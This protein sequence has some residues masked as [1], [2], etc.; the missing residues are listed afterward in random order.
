MRLSPKALGVFLTIAKYGAP[1]GVKGLQEAFGWG[2]RE[3]DTA[4]AEL[5]AMRLIALSSG[6]TSKGTF[7]HKIE[8]T[9]EGKA[10]VYDWN[11]PL[12]ILPNGETYNSISLNSSMAD[13]YIADIPYSQ[14]QY[15]LYANSVNQGAKQSFAQR[16][17]E[18]NMSLGSM[19]E[20]PDDIAAEKEKD[21]K[22]KK[23]KRKEESE[24]FYRKRQQVRANKPIEKWT[25]TDIVNYFAEQCKNVW[26]VE[27]V[28]ITQRPRLVR[29]MDTFRTDND[30]DG[31]LDKK[32]MDMFLSTYKF[33]HGRLYNPEQLFW[34]FLNYAP[35]AID[36]AKRSLQPEDVD[37]VSA[38]KAKAKAEREEYLRSMGK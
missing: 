31:V 29:A 30:T 22:R 13:T 14:E 9:Q 5:A 11:Q 8:L 17:E 12:Y 37:V 2:R 24:A 21:A 18:T 33:D 25:P 32:L 19:P 10:F 28:A 15:G 34:T 1:R 23:E 6:K 7:W 26:Q 35:K 3:I 27:Q 20:D 38:A 36:E 16:K 4:L